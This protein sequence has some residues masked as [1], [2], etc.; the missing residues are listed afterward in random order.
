M[1]HEFDRCVLDSAT[2]QLWTDGELQ[3]IEPQVLRVLEVLV[4]NADRMVTKLELLD[5]VWGDRFVS[6]SALTSR[7]KLARRAC[8]DSGREQRIIKTVHGRGYRVVA[9][10]STRDPKQRSTTSARPAVGRP[11]LGLLVGRDDELALL[12]DAAADVFE[13][14]SR[15]VFVT[16]EAGSGKSALL[17]E[18]LERTDQLDDWWVLRGQCVQ[19]R[20]GVEPYFTL[21]DALT[22][23]AD[24]R[25]DELVEVMERVAP[26]WLAQIPSLVDDDVAVRLERKLLG[27]GP[28]RMLREGVALIDELAR[29]RPTVLL[30]EDLHWADD[31]TLDVLDLLLQRASAGLL[32]IATVR[33]E[34]SAADELIGRA[35]VSGRTTD[36]TLG[37]LS[38]ADVADLLRDRLGVDDVPEGLVDVVC[39]RCDGV[40]LFA[41][42]IVAAML[43]E[44]SI[45]VGDG[46]V[47]MVRS[48]REI[49]ETVPASLPPLVERELARL[50][51]DDR[52]LLEAAAISGV[53]FD[54]ATVA[55]AL[56][57]SIDDVE[58]ALDRLARS[59]NLITATGGARW[60]DGTVSTA[61]SFDHALFR[62]IV[63]D[64]IPAH[65]RALLHARVGTALEQ[66]HDGHLDEITA[67]LADHFVEAGD[68]TRAIEYLRR[69]GELAAARSAH[70]LAIEIFED[71]SARLVHLAPE[72]RDRAELKLRVALGPSLV[73]VR[74]WIDAAV[75]SN[76][77]R[78]VEL[79]RPYPTAPETAAARYGLATVT[80][81]RGQFERTESLL[82]PLLALD[83]D[84]LVVEAHEL[85]AC[86]R[87]HQGAFRQ[88]FDSAQVVLDS[89]DEE[90]Y[91]VLMARIAEHPAS[92]CN[93]WSSLAAW[94]LGR[95]DD[96]LELADRAVELGERN[97]YALSTAVQQR[98][99]LHQVR[100]EVDECERWALRTGEVGREQNFPMRMIQADIYRGWALGARGS[101][102]E[103]IELIHDG[104]GRF[105]AAGAHLNEAYY[106]GLFA[107]TLLS[108]DRPDEALRHV[109]DALRIM[110][111]S[112]RSYFHESELHRV[113]AGALRA[114]GSGT[115]EV[116][117]ALETSWQIAQGRNSPPLR[118][119]TASDRLEFEL[120][121]D[122]EGSWRLAVTE[123]LAAFDGQHP[124]PDTMRARAL[125]GT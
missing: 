74:G 98:A 119:R 20:G 5:E 125:L 4:T 112:T 40:A 69:A 124:V 82:E 97:P 18:W 55:A 8:G 17:A 67:E 35:V 1:I 77:E 111:S 64:H 2:Q 93:S 85:I 94:Y 61:M 38:R 121:H 28:Q 75:G 25:P 71:A 81:L 16:G 24:E 63:C 104:L 45:V 89:W 100:R 123:A 101:T 39:E 21:L 116:R 95:A 41:H 37:P 107:E 73:A 19:T 106:L 117:D 9:D 57:R 62:D 23:L 80:E 32:V 33:N 15:A 42:E 91:S 110:G 51:H 22:L 76:Y 48:A 59:S 120:A 6:E 60:P 7:I 122:D 102:D 96:S 78:A 84:H 87:F 12:D 11:T 14:R 10:V 79:A 68:Q 66:G 99:M 31:C 70:D 65:R 118:L 52:A 47:R 34:R 88:S 92:S 13:G 54:G 43:R 83:E 72:D 58:D 113:R 50:D 105:H 49:A 108:A 109:D 114:V 27:S 29:S 53:V 56:D 103:A 90:L 115:A 44:G 36:L 3:H 46:K 86:S 26:T 30:I